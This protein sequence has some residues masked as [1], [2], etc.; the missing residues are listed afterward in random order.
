MNISTVWPCGRGAPASSG[1]TPRR[2]PSGRLEDRV[3]AKCVGDGSLALTRLRH[4]LALQ[5][6]H[7]AL[8]RFQNGE[9]VELA[10]EDLRLAARAMGRI[11]GRVDVEDVLDSIFSEF[12]I[13]K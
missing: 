11:T 3:G 8:Q 10:A 13:G 4:R 5:E 9:M 7:E 6:C 12:C 1:I 2:I